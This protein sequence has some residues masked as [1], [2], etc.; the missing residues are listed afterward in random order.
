MPVLQLWKIPPLISML[1]PPPSSAGMWWWLGRSLRGWSESEGLMG[2]S[3]LM[4][5]GDGADSMFLSLRSNTHSRLQVR[6]VPLALS[7]EGNTKYTTY[8]IHKKPLSCITGLGLNK[9]ERIQQIPK[10]EKFAKTILFPRPVS[11]LGCV[12]VSVSGQNVSYNL[13]IWSQVS[14]TG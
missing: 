10:E 2:L 8:G 6:H 11:T 12:T 14:E 1:P 3:A 7:Y 5:C 9:A 13:S 4:V